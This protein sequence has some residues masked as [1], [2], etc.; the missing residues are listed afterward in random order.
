MKMCGKTAVD[1]GIGIGALVS[2]KAD[3]WM[4]CHAQG[5]LAIVYWFQ[6]HSGSIMVCCEHG[7]VPHDGTKND[8]WV[9]YDKYR[10]IARNDATFPISNNLQVMRDKLLA[11]SF[12]NDRATPQISF[13]KYVNID[14]GTTSPV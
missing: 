8:Y 6:E 14:L 2:L 13:S 4:H 11:G 7:I 1:S 9:P 3:Y 12:I 10:V 5:L